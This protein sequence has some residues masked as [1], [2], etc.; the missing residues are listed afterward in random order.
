MNK[1]YWVEKIIKYQVMES[2]ERDD[3]A[4]GEGSVAESDHLDDANNV[5]RVLASAA[6]T[7]AKTLDAAD[8]SAA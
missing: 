2:F 3:G 8:T 5:A 7:A 4:A 6:G 1:H